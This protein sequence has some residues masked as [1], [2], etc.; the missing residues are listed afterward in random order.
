MMDETFECPLSP[1]LLPGCATTIKISSDH[2]PTS[3]ICM[4]NYI[5]A[6]K[7]ITVERLYLTYSLPTI[8]F[9]S[10][11]YVHRLTDWFQLFKKTMSFWPQCFG[12]LVFGV[13]CGFGGRRK[14]YRGV[15]RHLEEHRPQSVACVKVQASR[16]RSLRCIIA[17]VCHR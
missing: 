11:F 15:I 13:F 6:R 2:S 10:L 5:V 7:L 3:V 12:W 17:A 16:T 1:V 14:L 8:D 9:I 4:R